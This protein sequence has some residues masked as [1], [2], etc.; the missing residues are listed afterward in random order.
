MNIQFISVT[1][2]ISLTTSD[3]GNVYQLNNPNGNSTIALPTPTDGFNAIFVDNNSSGYTYSFSTPSGVIVKYTKNNLNSTPVLVT[4]NSTITLNG[5]VGI[6]YFI[7]SD[8]VNYFL[9]I[10][11]IAFPSES[12]SVTG[13]DLTMSGSTG[14]DITNA[15]LVPTGVTAGTYGSNTQIPQVTVDAKG[16]VTSATVLSIFTAQ[17]TVVFTSSGT[18]TVPDG[19]YRILVS[20]CAGGGGG[21]SY[22]SG[23]AQGGG[24]GGAGQSVI[25]QVINVTPGSIINITIGSGGNGADGI[26]TAIGESGGDTILSIENNVLLHLDSGKGGNSETSQG[27][28]GEGY[29]SG[30]WGISSNYIIIGGDG[31]SSMF[32][33][34]GAGGLGKYVQTWKGGLVWWFILYEPLDAYGYGAGG[35]GGVQDI[36]DNIKSGTNGTSGIIIIEW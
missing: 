5:N 4:T 14:I 31:A 17:N 2:S 11:P 8:G 30:G 22:L 7:S 20:G 10:V 12:I 32:G 35:G 29:P 24:G 27:H 9:Y 1:S 15:T 13:T 18:W 6:E 25:K 34:G 33:V 26:N 23:D 19:V 36:W 16:R 21:G 3:S 28:Y